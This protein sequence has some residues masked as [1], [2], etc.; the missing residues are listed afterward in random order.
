[1]SVDYLMVVEY[2]FLAVYFLSVLVI[3]IAMINVSYYNK[4]EAAVGTSTETNVAKKYSK[5]IHRLDLFGKIVHPALIVFL[6]GVL[7]YW[8]GK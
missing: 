4:I 7:L 1:M 8:Y 6:I 2:F 5:K 3:F